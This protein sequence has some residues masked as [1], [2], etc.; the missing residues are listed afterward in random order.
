MRSHLP[1]LTL[2][3]AL[4][5]CGSTPEQRNV[6]QLAEACAAQQ[7]ASY[8]AAREALQ[9]GYPVGPRC[10]ATLPP[11]AGADACGA[12]SAD[13][14]L[15]QVVYYWFV[16]DPAVCEGGS[17]TCELRLVKSDSD[18]QGGD[19]VVCAVRFLKGQPSP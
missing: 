15:C 8:T 13:R 3:A 4:A 2:V 12:A 10:S 14:E 6:D 7:G 16:A 9:G 5:A 17:C 1:G 18:A 11:I 19:A